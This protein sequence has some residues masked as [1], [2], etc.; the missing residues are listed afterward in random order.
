M[1][2]HK[3]RAGNCALDYIRAHYT[4]SSELADLVDCLPPLAFV[5][6]NQAKREAS[7]LWDGGAGLTL[8][9]FGKVS[10]KYRLLTNC[11]IDLMLVPCFNEMFKS[12]K[13]EKL[14]SL[15]VDAALY[16]ATGCEAGTPTE[17]EI[18]DEGTQRVR[19]VS[20]YALGRK[21]LRVADVEGWM[22]GKEYAALM[23]GNPKDLPYIVAVRP[24]TVRIRG[25][26]KLI[27]KYWLYGTEFAETDLERVSRR[28][29]D[30]RKK[31]RQTIERLPSGSKK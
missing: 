6:R 23:T 13:D 28:V 24:Y 2:S 1:I 21:Y 12:G 29:D 11:I 27:A 16:E 26:G 15:L 22:F 7:E 20:K 4:L 19:G 25:V 3:L 17:S 10:G 31:L 5:L 14:T 18:L 30:A 9:L 8:R